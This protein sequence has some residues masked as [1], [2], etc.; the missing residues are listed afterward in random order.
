LSVLASEQHG[1]DLRIRPRIYHKS[2]HL[3]LAPSKRMQ[4]AVAVRSAPGSAGWA[5]VADP[6]QLVLGGVAAARGAAGAK[7]V[8]AA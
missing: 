7:A 1:G 8:A 5:A 2:R 3:Q 6:P 4:Q